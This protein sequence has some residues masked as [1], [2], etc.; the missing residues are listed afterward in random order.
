MI[1]YFKEMFSGLNSLFT[2]MKITG[3]VAFRK[4]ITV[5]YPF[6]RMEVTPNF[7]GHTDLIIE[8][9]FHKCI[10]C[11]MCERICPSNC[12]RII[13]EKPEGAKKKELI[14]YHLDFTKCSLCA[15]CVE[16]CPTSALY[17][18]HEYT[19]VGTSRHDFHFNLLERA[20]KRAA[21]DGIVWGPPEPEPK[22]ES[23]K[24]KKEAAAAPSEAQ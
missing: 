18:S 10:T 13:A 22:T 8:K 21:Q 1:S 12:I 4:P 5:H 17:F 16:I 11:G 3:K 9:G 20:K 14:A 2:G 23:E 7:R 15:N 24:P 6:E 19:L